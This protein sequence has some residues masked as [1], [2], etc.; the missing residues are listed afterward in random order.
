MFEAARLASLISRVQDYDGRSWLTADEVLAMA[1]AG[2]SRALG[3]G[4]RIGRM[5]PGAKAD[6]VFL[7]LR[8]IHYVPLGDV[9]RQIA[10]TESGAAVDSVM[11]GGQMVLDRGRLMTIDED[12]LRRDAERACER[13]RAANAENQEFAARLERVVRSFCIGLCRSPYHVHR[14]ANEQSQ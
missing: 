3:F 7:D 9:V 4:D 10:F 6:I 5:A 12:K 8:H 14:L 2:S 11:I 1:T 13:L